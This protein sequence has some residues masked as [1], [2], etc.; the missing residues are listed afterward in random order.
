MAGKAESGYRGLPRA[1]APARLRR[2]NRNRAGSAQ[3]SKQRRGRA[4]PAPDLSVIDGARA[5]AESVGDPAAPAFSVGAWGLIDAV[6][7]ADGV[8]EISL[9]VVRADCKALGLLLL[10]I[11]GAVEEAG[12]GLPRLYTRRARRWSFAD[13]RVTDHHGLAETAPPCRRAPGM[14]GGG[15]IFPPCAAVCRAGREPQAAAAC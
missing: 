7:L 2:S 6:T 9:R 10:T 11:E 15:R 3:L 1:A 14:D 12:Y 13:M 5:V 8:V 4:V